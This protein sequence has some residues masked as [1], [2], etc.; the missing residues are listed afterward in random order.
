[1]NI[2]LAHTQGG[3]ITGS[4]DESVR[5][6]VTK[7]AHIHFTSTAESTKNVIQLGEDPSMV[8]NTG[9]PSIDI[10]RESKPLDQETF[11]AY[12]GTGEVISL[13]KP[14]L[15]VA[16]HPV[17]TEY[18]S[19]QSQIIE[20]INAVSEIGIPTIWLWPNIDAGTEEISKGLRIFRE[21]G[22]PNLIGFY[23]NFSPEHFAALLNSTA[24]VVGNSSCGIREAAFLGTPAVN[25]G[26]RQNGRERGP[27]VI[28]VDHDSEQISKAV[29]QQLSHGPYESSTLFGSGDTGK[30][31][32]EKLA[33]LNVVV[34]K[35]FFK[36]S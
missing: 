32:S 1:M 11:G 10:A 14:F 33:S 30:L 4:I 6:A 27:N 13:E 9:C 34:Q 8:F 21:R 29:S 23:K 31:I 24:C 17:T 26:T 28:D 12:H 3:E 18:G 15:L 7:L 35:Q 2:P 20:T 5:H 22:G 16:Q 25:I 36:V 19:G